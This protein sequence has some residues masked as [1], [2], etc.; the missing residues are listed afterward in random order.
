MERADGLGDTVATFATLRF[1]FSS[2]VENEDIVMY[3]EPEGVRYYTE[4]NDG[5][6]TLSLIVSG[7]L[8]GATRYSVTPAQEI[9]AAGASPIRPHSV[10]FE[11]MTHAREN[12]PNDC[13][14]IADVFTNPVCGEVSAAG[15]T[16]CFLLPAPAAGSIYLRTH[17]AGAAL[18]LGIVDSA[19]NDTAVTG[20][21][22]VK[23][24]AVPP[25]FTFP[26]G[27]RVFST[28]G[29]GRYELGAGLQ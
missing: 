21:I 8:D 27:A 14:A 7:M 4:L 10:R 29:T 9:R 2:P 19:G 23:S 12:E 26:V 16:D 13:I 25:S 17:D 18:G 20:D 24:L 3:L 28:L 22:P 5:S 1:S 15:D 6:D 11:F